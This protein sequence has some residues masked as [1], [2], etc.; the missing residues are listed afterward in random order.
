ME[1]SL[2]SGNLLSFTI[3]NNEHGKPLAGELARIHEVVNPLVIL[4]FAADLIL[5]QITLLAENP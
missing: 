5:L 3:L 1:G 4:L 2:A